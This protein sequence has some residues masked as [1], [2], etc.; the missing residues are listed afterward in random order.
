[1]VMPSQ[2]IRRIVHGASPGISASTP[3]TEDQIQP[4]SLDLRLGS[5]I[6]RVWS[7]SLP[8]QYET[9]KDM[10]SREGRHK[11]HFTLERE[12]AHFLEK[13]HT[14]VVELMESCALP[15]HEWIEFSPKSSTGRCDVF[16]RV[17]CDKHSHYDMTP[18]G[19]HGSLYLEITPLSFDVGVR[20][21]LSLVQGRIKSDDTHMLSNRELSDLQRDHG[22]LRNRDGRPLAQGDITIHDSELYYHIDLDRP[23]VGFEAKV[24]PNMAL[25]MNAGKEG[26]PLCDP[27]DFWVPIERPKNGRLVLV[28]NTFYLLATKERTYIPH[29]V[30]GQVTSFKIT[31]GE[32]RPHYAGFF[33][34]AFGEGEDP[35][36]KGTNGVLEVRVRDV[37]FEV[38]DGSPICSMRY[39]R[40]FEIPDKLYGKGIESNYPKPGPSLSKHFNDRYLAWEAK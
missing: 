11:Y 16:A 27:K 33:D 15:K 17:L 4:A 21:G 24:Q 30:C 6:W 31:T 32:L 14:Y 34:P 39:E 8:G 13:G 2:R 1:M 26:I 37:A 38:S 19:Y 28:P 23:I 25:D 10:V 18:H 20:E 35:N 9:V 29:D 36:I 5:N 22:V 3:I 40:M 12:K 7:A